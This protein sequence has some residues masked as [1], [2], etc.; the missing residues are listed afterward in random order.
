MT[1]ARYHGRVELAWPENLKSLL[2]HN[3]VFSARKSTNTSR[4]STTL[5]PTFFFPWLWHRQC[6]RLSSFSIFVMNLFAAFAAASMVVQASRSQQVRG[7]G[8][9]REGRSYWVNV[10]SPWLSWYLDTSC[11]VV[12]GVATFCSLVLL[13]IMLLSSYWSSPQWWCSL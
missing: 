3:S 11:C 12:R 2:G 4:A 7:A 13:V 5:V 10:C 6:L 9:L 8:D 1:Y